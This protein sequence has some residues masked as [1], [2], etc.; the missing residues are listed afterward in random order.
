M[1][2]IG[3][4]NIGMI[5][6]SNGLNK[7]LGSA[8]T[9]LSIFSSKAGA[10]LGSISQIAD[11]LT[12]G[13]AG[14]LIPQ[15]EQLG[16]SLVSAGTTGASALGGLAL[17]AGTSVAAIA[18][19]TAA[20]VGLGVSAIKP[21]ADLIHLS[22][23][24]G[25]TVDGLKELH[26]VAR[27][28]GSDV[29]SMDTALG[30]LSI[31]LGKALHGSTPA[32]V[33]LEQI[34]LNAKQLAT[35]DPS[36]AM[37]R[38]I[39]NFDKFPTAADQAAAAIELFGKGGIGILGTLKLGKEGLE[40][41]TKEMGGVKGALDGVNGKQILEA[42]ASMEK[43]AMA[44]SGLGTTIAVQIAPAV[45]NVM[46]VM[47][48]WLKSATKDGSALNSV[49][50][51]TTAIVKGL[52][53]ASSW[54]PKDTPFWKGVGESMGAR[55]QAHVGPGKDYTAAGKWNPTQARLEREKAAAANAPA[56]VAPKAAAI[57]N[58]TMEAIVKGREWVKTLGEQTTTF[59][60]TADA[61][62][63]YKLKLAGIPEQDVRNIGSLIELK[64]QMERSK[65]VWDQMKSDAV[66]FFT[67]TR[68][69]AERLIEQQTKL[70]FLL[71]AGLI[72]GETFQR[73]V[74]KDLIDKARSIVDETRTPLELY[75]SKLTEL[76]QMLG[77]GIISQDTYGRAVNQA[78]AN[79][80]EQKPQYADMAL[81]GSKE[82]YTAIMQHQF[83]GSKSEMTSIAANTAQQVN[84]QKRQTTLLEA[85]AGAFGASDAFGM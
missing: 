48:S 63:L 62:E 57:S 85:I 20:V 60:M 5:V 38:I 32:A 35:M 75:Q 50:T 33:A 28:S 44:W 23:R 19:A 18:A 67:E 56:P 41:L 84:E 14:K 54:K 10:S 81:A 36:Q 16:G 46:G 1:A 9:S 77:K 26:Y 71:K 2:T 6:D 64:T 83:G 31:N 15:I 61:A 22:E 78:K 55:V 40:K 37:E 68:T 72:S 80:P 30:K 7:G 43:L 11:S 24:L 12:G 3:N 65:A 79:L 8:S 25:A 52:A 59:G 27:L 51:G 69:P 45:T 66:S 4:I 82:A 53:N 74:N 21:A 73:A 58:E 49:L 34:G 29:E 13:M 47:T 39:A 76:Q 70:N 17:A 42:H